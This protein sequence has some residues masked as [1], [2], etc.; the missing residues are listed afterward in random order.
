M[1]YWDFFYFEPSLFIR[2]SITVLILNLDGLAKNLKNIGDGKVWIVGTAQQTLT[3]DDAKAALNSPE[4]F[5]LNDRFPIQIALESNDIK[6]ICYTRLLG[7][8]AAAEAES[9]RD[10]AAEKLWRAGRTLAPDAPRRRTA[11]DARGAL[12]SACRW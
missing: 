6:E 5:K 9:P 12:A 2:Y 11:S 8:S 1:P 3:A 7:K 10:A 4:L